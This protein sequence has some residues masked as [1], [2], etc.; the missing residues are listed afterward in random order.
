[1]YDNKYHFIT[2]TLFSGLLSGFSFEMVIPGPHTIRISGLT[3]RSDS[4]LFV[5]DQIGFSSTIYSPKSRT[6]E[7]DLINIVDTWL[8]KIG[9]SQSFLINCQGNSKISLNTTVSCQPRFL[10]RAKYAIFIV[11]TQALFGS[12]NKLYTQV[13]GY[14]Y[15]DILCLIVF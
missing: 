12:L 11:N 6:I 2:F 9:Y 15:N 8:D 10:R 14:E 3:F 1:M 7:I 4:D 5:N 13:F